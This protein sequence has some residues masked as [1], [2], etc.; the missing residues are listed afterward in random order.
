MTREPIDH[1]LRPRLPWRDDRLTECGLDAQG[2]Q[3]VVERG[4]YLQRK[5]EMGQQ[6]CALFHCMT[7]MQTVQRWPTWAED[8][9]RALAREIEWERPEYFRYGDPKRGDRLR[10]EL[11]AIAVLL[12]RHAEEFKSLVLKAEQ[13]AQWR[14][15]LD[16]TTGRP[17]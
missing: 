1:I 6:R 13:Q 7:C 16:K 5:K 2:M 11:D 8:P 3:N 4:A 9:R 12:E 14:A 15:R 10:R 17:Q